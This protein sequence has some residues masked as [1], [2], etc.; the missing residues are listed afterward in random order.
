MKANQMHGFSVKTGVGDNNFHMVHHGN[1]LP[2][3]MACGWQMGINVDVADEE[4]VQKLRA[5]MT[6]EEWEGECDEVGDSSG[7][8]LVDSLEV[9]LDLCSITPPD[10]G[11]RHPT[12]KIHTD[13]IHFA[14]AWV[15]IEYPK[16]QKIHV[17]IVGLPDG[18]A[19]PNDHILGPLAARENVV[20]LQ[21]LGKFDLDVA[22]YR[23]RWKRIWKDESYGF[24]GT[25]PIKAQ[26]RAEAKKRQ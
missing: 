3:D 12:V 14:L 8:W 6:E 26:L 5:S 19:G 9:T 22:E 11:D 18:A 25:D 13:A 1:R 2:E 4:D 20:V 21:D 7:T 16:A 15:T 24:W 10:H 17:Q 23:K